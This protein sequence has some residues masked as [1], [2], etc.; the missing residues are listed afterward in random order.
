MARVSLATGR[1]LSET[2]DHKLHSVVHRAGAGLSQ[3]CHLLRE[4]CS[5]P[6]RHAT[7]EHP[8]ESWPFTR[9]ASR[10]GSARVT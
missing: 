3:I 8:F 6:V 1:V 10:M 4:A 5:R 2:P 7:G 9:D